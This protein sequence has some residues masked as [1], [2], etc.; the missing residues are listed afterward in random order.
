MKRNGKPT[1]AFLTTQF[2]R[3]T[4]NSSIWFGI[5]ETSREEDINVIC[6]PINPI[7]YP[8]DYYSMANALFNLVTE[9]NFDGLLI[10]GSGIANQAT[11]GDLKSFYDK[12]LSYPTI[13]ISFDI[14]GIP[15]IFIDNYTGMYDICNHLIEHHHCKRLAFIRGPEQH[16]E[17]DDRYRAY[18]DVLHQHNLDVEPALIITGDFSKTGGLQCTRILLDERRVQFDALVCSNDLM[19]FGAMLEL[20]KRNRDI[21]GEI[22]VTGFDNLAECLN[23]KAPLTTVSQPFKEM[24]KA[25]TRMLLDMIRGKQ[26]DNKVTI[27]SKLII[28]QSCGC[29]DPAADMQVRNPSPVKTALKKKDL[30]NCAKKELNIAEKQDKKRIR[31]LELFGDTL[32]NALKNRVKRPFLQAVSSELHKARTR[33]EISE[34]T[35]MVQIMLDKSIM[36]ATDNDMSLLIE[37]IIYRSRSAICEFDRKLINYQRLVEN[38]ENDRLQSFV[39]RFIAS[40]NLTKFFHMLAE[41]FPRIGITECFIVLY[42]APHISL[43]K[44]VLKLAINGNN[45]MLPDDNA[46]EFDSNEIVPDMF[47]AS[48]DR[49]A[50]IIEPL[51]FEN[52]NLGF[53]VFGEDF[54]IND[55][56]TTLQRVLSATLKG[57]LLIQ[58]KEDLLIKLKQKAHDLEVVADK[59]H[60]SNRELEQFS[61][62]AS[63][64]LKEPVRKM[65]FFSERIKQKYVSGMDEKGIDLLQRMENA[66]TRM[67]LLINSLLDYSRITTHS[68][69]FVT[70]NLHSMVNTVLNDLEIPIEQKHAHIEIGELPELEA[71]PSQIQ[72]LFQN[73]ISNAIKFQEPGCIPEVAI[74]SRILQLEA[75]PACEITVADNGIG[76]KEEYFATIFGVFQRLHSHREYEGSGIGLAI[77]KKVVD[78]HKGTIK[79]E[80]VYGKGTRFIITLP[81]R[82]T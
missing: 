11:P 58:E 32:A 28:R 75:T 71:D 24:G 61:F 33:M 6:L 51:Y 19:A 45:T 4:V 74:T 15:S 76:I 3:N 59:L 66:A 25:A 82:Q 40:F 5:Y 36:N 54:L 8:H 72:Q 29:N 13:N 57:A 31:Q 42:S 22:K 14:A 9:K 73:L 60:I 53:V 62:I 20:E 39:F 34:I 17:A 26:P 46:I 41:E 67:V 23:Q 18:Q 44:A 10:W 37:N 78:R 35:K 56:Y 65:Q 55:H 48:A 7:N 64:D 49:F 43:E 1:I 47:S 2:S 12:V 30:I 80:S 68:K 70:V 63:H 81:L 77:C 50:Y 21:P 69:P 52:E 79:V 27:P 16:S 38:Y